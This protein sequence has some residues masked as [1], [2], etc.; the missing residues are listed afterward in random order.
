[1][2]RIVNL[3]GWVLLTLGA[4]MLCHDLVKW[5][6]SGEFGVID[7]GTLWHSVHKESLAL[8][9]PA[10]ERHVHPFLWDPV[11]LNILLAPAFVVFGLPGG[12]LVGLTRI[13]DR[14]GHRDLFMG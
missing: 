7:F 8:A 2:R 11:M 12:L 4:V 14:N 9:N 10:I 1:M 13:R 6:L 5:L 3:V